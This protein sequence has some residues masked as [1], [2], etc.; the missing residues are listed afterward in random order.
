MQ[1]AARVSDYTMFMLDGRLI[2]YGPTVVFSPS[3][4]I[5]GL[6]SISQVNWS[7]FARKHPGPKGKRDMYNPRAS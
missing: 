4:K 2:E 5:P 3:P 6:R 7:D 1:Q